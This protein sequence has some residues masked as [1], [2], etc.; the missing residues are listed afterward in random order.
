[1]KSLYRL[2]NCSPDDTAS[3]SWRIAD[4]EAGKLARADALARFGAVTAENLDE[5]TRYM[6]ERRISHRA[7]I[8]IG[9]GGAR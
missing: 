5:I 8:I 4:Q 9:S 2:R 1:M 7:R 3:A 6:E